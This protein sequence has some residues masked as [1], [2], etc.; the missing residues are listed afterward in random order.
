M[1][2]KIIY[3]RKFL[4]CAAV[5]CLAAAVHA[6]EEFD[7]NAISVSGLGGFDN[8]GAVP[9]P[10]PAAGVEGISG[11]ALKTRTFAFTSEYYIRA[12]D[13]TLRLKPNL[14]R[15]GRDY[16]WEELALPAEAGRV[17]AISADGNNLIAVS[18]TGRVLYMNF[19]PRAWHV[20]WGKPFGKELYLPP[21]RGWAISHRGPE[22]GGFEDPDGKFHAISVG[23]TT[24]Y[25]LS[26]DGTEIR[27][28][29]PWLS[30]E[31]NYRLDTPLEGRFIGAA[32][33]ASGSTLFVADA[34]GRMFTRLADFDTVGSDPLLKYSFEPSARKDVIRLPAENWRRQPRI[35]GRITSAITI[36]QTGKG[37]AGRELRV[38]GVDP[39]GYGGYY[40]KGI[41]APAWSFVRTGRPV[42]G[43]FLEGTET[44]TAAAVRDYP[45]TYDRPLLRDRL[46]E[47]SVIRNF[48]PNNS[49]AE[50]VVPGLENTPLK[51]HTRCTFMPNRPAETAKFYGTIEVPD[52]VMTSGAP[53][54]AGLVKKIGKKK[55]REVFVKVYDDR[56]ELSDNVL[57]S[58]SHFIRRD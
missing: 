52:A 34:A 49:V 12:G 57:Y 28:T 50:I 32:L 19:K 42:S 7:L 47:G 6:G 48:G 15:T 24:L 39:E 31:F 9:A 58:I 55:F 16:D 35:D 5:I 21:N 41:Y 56:V 30:A 38:E 20:K 13:G 44:E 53:A 14:E 33:S 22:A 2:S 17:G 18:E 40:A 46:P 1:I 51:F 54:A 25:L 37:N 26:E 3:M 8:A 11:F 10:S 29:D 23:V 43:P 36:L 4:S 27:Y 45:V